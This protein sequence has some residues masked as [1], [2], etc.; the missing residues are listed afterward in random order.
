MSF[1]G[2]G[3]HAD[4]PTF[5]ELIAADRLVTTLQ[6]AISYGL[7][8]YGQRSDLCRRL[9]ER[10]D[11]VFFLVRLMLE[12][13]SLRT[14]G[15]SFAEAVYGLRRVPVGES[16]LLS[17]SQKRLSLMLLT[18]QPF[19]KGTLMKLY[20]RTMQQNTRRRTTCSRGMESLYSALRVGFQKACPLWYTS[21]EALDLGYK[22]FY[23]LGMTPYYSPGLH[24][25]GIRIA[26]ISPQD[27][28]R[29][30]RE[31]IQHRQARLRA[32]SRHHHGRGWLSS[33][34]AHIKT[35]YLQT[36]YYVN[37]HATTGLVL[38]V[39]GFKLVEWWYTSAQE[40]MHGSMGTK[41]MPIPPPPPQIPPQGGM[42]TLPKE[43]HICAICR[44]TRVNPTM[45]SKTGYVFCYP[46][47]FRHVQEHGSCP[48]TGTC[49]ISMSDL[50]RLFQEEDNDDCM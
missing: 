40:R 22:L 42:Y 8:V 28:A 48:V 34:L 44:K 25:L 11:E 4:V 19:L 29:I 16:L 33:V 39:F 20:K 36:R 50:C 23:L 43:T 6:D 15:A 35:R 10:E 31:K 17:P 45:V 12:R 1:T 27:H 37:D 30:L 13:V 38:L 2:V 41:N 21:A 18:L 26:R 24:M 3:S 5:F 14:H 49:P 32:V 46:C 7:S 47:V 9:L